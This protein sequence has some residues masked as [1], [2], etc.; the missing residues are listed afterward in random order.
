[1][2]DTKPGS[3]I[4]KAVESAAITLSPETVKRYVNAVASEQEI[5]LFLNQC[6]MFGLNPFK[7]EIYLIK[8]K[9]TEPATFVVGYE[10]YLKRAERTDKWAGMESGTTDVDGKLAFAWVK[11]YRKDWDRPLYHEVFLDE[12]CQFKDEWVNGSRTGRKTPTRFWAEK[13]RTMLKKVAIAQAF[14]MAFPDE[15]AGM[16]YISEERIAEPD[17]LPATE[18]VAGSAAYEASK[19]EPLK[20]IKDEFGPGEAKVDPKVEPTERSHGQAE[21]DDDPLLQAETAEDHPQ[22]DDMCSMKSVEKI[23]NLVAGLIG[24][25]VDESLIWRS[26][27]KKVREKYNV[28]FVET[29]DLTEKMAGDVAAYLTRW[30]K[31]AKSD[32]EGKK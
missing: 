7:R 22:P 8:Y 27:G 25:G 28:E 5:A 6:V 17:R 10:V 2:S 4:V 23:G 1:M 32:A 9:A 18:I 31:A 15:M 12:Y 30:T 11:V 20:N 16:P 14:R 13:P 24:L 26:I 29:S 19:K 3:S 21:M